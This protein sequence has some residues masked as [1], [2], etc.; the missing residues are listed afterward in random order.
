M[1]VHV[2]D[3]IDAGRPSPKEGPEESSNILLVLLDDG[4]FGWPSVNGGLVRTPTAERLVERGLF[5]NQFHTTALCRASCMTLLADANR[6]P[7]AGVRLPHVRGTRGP[8]GT[9]ARAVA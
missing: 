1:E 4:G 8:L 2:M 9:G 5:Y 6:R 3:G 7:G